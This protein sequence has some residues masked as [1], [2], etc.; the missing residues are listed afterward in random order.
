MYNEEDG[1]IEFTIKS[2]DGT[3]HTFERW[4]YPDH[5]MRIIE[6]YGEND[7]LLNH[8]VKLQYELGFF[9]GALIGKS[10]KKS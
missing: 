9:D 3:K 2:K 6:E 8:I 4:P 5:F 10:N 7:E 1:R